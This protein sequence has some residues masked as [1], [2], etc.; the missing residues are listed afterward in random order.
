[1]LERLQHAFQSQERFIADASHELKTPLAILRGELEVFRSRPRTEDEM[2]TFLNSALQELHHLSRV[3]EDLLILARIDAGTSILTKGAVYFEEIILDVI[4]KLEPLAR[5]KEV[6]IRIIFPEEPSSHLDS[7]D[8]FLVQ[9]D[10]D[11]L[12]VLIKNLVE[13]AIKYSPPNQ[14]VEVKFHLDTDWA[15]FEVTDHGPGIPHALL[16]KIFERFF[17]GPHSDTHLISG[18]GLGLA[19]AKRIAEIHGG[20]IEVVSTP[21]ERTTFHLQMRRQ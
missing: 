20:K 19:I 14:V 18:A 21:G 11:L 6:K 17:R 4:S 8:P 7:P 5:K 16:S 12:K 9:A 1:L 13:N 3:V 2:N 15:F 10:S